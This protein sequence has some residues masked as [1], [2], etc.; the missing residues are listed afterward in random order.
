[1]SDPELDEI[2]VVLDDDTP[3]SDPD[4]REPPTEPVVVDSPLD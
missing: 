1:M 4:D 3:N 2:V